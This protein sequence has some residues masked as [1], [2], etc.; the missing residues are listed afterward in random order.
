[1]EE[2]NLPQKKKAAFKE[3][4]FKNKWHQQKFSSFSLDSPLWNRGSCTQKNVRWN[5]NCNELEQSDFS[6]NKIIMVRLLWFGS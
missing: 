6:L 2:L 4:L 1:M 3:N 5:Y